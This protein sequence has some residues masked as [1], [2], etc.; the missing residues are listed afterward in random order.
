M[1]WASS[2]SASWTGSRWSCRTTGRSWAAPGSSQS[3]RRPRP[4]TLAARCAALWTT[5]ASTSSTRA[6]RR[7]WRCPATW[8]S[9]ASRPITPTSCACGT[10]SPPRRW[11]CPCS[12]RASTC[13]PWSSTQWRRPSPRCSIPRTITMRAN[14][15][16]S[17]SSTSSSP[18]RC[19]PSCASTSRSATR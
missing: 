2:A 6:R 5:A 10:P 7:C 3:R 16:A 13:A 19:S 12:R 9:R 14:P 17:S 11:I 15:C 18:P 8:R 1:S 4:S